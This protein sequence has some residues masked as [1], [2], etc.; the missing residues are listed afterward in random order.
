MNAI[1]SAVYDDDKNSIITSFEKGATI[2][3]YCGWIED[4]FGTTIASR[5]ELNQLIDSA[6]QEYAELV[7]FGGLQE[8][9]NG[10][11][12]VYVQQRRAVTDEFL[13]YSSLT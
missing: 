7:L 12:C 4:G 6:P 11:Q 13:L 3:I 2:V 10:C 8:Y 5:S 1:T 9:L